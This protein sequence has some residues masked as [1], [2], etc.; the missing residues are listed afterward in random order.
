M[1]PLGWITER[2]AW[3]ES[4]WPAGSSPGSKWGF[5]LIFKINYP[6]LHL[7]QIGSL[8]TSYRLSAFCVCLPVPNWQK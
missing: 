7:I 3:L 1:F 6:I 4:G 2:G 5:F 8:D